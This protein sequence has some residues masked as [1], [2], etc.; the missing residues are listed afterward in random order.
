M[1]PIVALTFGL[2][3]FL[4]LAAA[5]DEQ[6]RGRLAQLRIFSLGNL[7]VEFGQDVPKLRAT[8]TQRFAEVDRAIAR[9]YEDTIKRHDLPALFARLKAEIDKQIHGAFGVDLSS[10]NHRAT[11]YVPG[12]AGQELVQATDYIPAGKDSRK[13]IGR[14]FSVRYGIIGR[15]FRLRS[16]MYNWEVH[17]RGNALV[18]HWGLTRTEAFKQGS[19]T[20]SLM[21]FPIPPDVTDEP[22]GVVYLEVEGINELMPNIPTQDLDQRV[23]NDP[24]GRLE[25]DRLVNDEIWMPIWQANLANPVFEA[26]KGMR[27]EFSW[28]NPLRAEDGR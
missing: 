18:R 8:L 3:L 6:F 25:A 23:P 10:R 19:G 24:E 1:G 4:L 7:S 27:A 20:T 13:V 14:R 12:F 15:T 2:L 11:L 26:L 17:N 9:S 22:V 21:A 28:N 16:A 5:F